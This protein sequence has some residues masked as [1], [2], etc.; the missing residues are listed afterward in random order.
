M[1]FRAGLRDFRKHD[2]IT[3]VYMRDY[4][5]YYRAC[6]VNINSTLFSKLCMLPW[7]EAALSLR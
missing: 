7:D 6:F 3:S 1:I 4:T 2:R 5:E